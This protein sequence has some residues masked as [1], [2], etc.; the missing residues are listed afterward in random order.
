MNIF[1]AARGLKSSS[2]DIRQEELTL[3][4]MIKKAKQKK[5]KKGRPGEGR[6]IKMSR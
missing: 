4:E 5:T 1:F 2:E 6:G 3:G